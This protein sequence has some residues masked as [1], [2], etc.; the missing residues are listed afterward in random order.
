MVE[1]IFSFEKTFTIDIMMWKKFVVVFIFLSLSWILFV[2]GG[3]VNE[4]SC[5]L[6][7]KLKNSYDYNWESRKNEWINTKSK[8]DYLVLS[9]SW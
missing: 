1:I 5:P 3:T 7:S 6:P 2:N 9:L 8:T 4:K